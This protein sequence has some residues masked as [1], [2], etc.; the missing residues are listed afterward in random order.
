MPRR[1]PACTLHGRALVR[2]FVVDVCGARQDWTSGR[3]ID[4]HVASIR[5]RV[6]QGR[7]LCALSGGVDSSVVAALMS[8]RCSFRSSAVMSGIGPAPQGVTRTIESA[9]PSLAS[10]GHTSKGDFHTLGCGSVPPT[11]SSRYAPASHLRVSPLA[12]APESL[13]SDG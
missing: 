3:F 2:R 12:K 8:F 5:A 7:V 1:V 11:H 6:G 13:R 10:A 9:L 4:E